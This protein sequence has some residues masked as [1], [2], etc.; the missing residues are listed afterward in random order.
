MILTTEPAAAREVCRL[1]LVLALDVSGSVDAAEYRLQLD[2]LAE[3]LTRP[4]VARTLLAGP[5]VALAAFEWS[6]PRETRPLFGWTML[7]GPETLADLA[8]R[9]R[10]TERSGMSERTAIGSAM[11]AGEALLRDGPDCWRRVI[12]ISGDGQSNS[13]PPPSALR[14]DGI[15]V[16]AL[17]V[18]ADDPSPGDRRA[19]EISELSSYFRVNVLRGPGAFVQVAL[20]FDDF[21]R[22][23]ARKLIREADPAI[24]SAR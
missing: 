5:P 10:A 19:A 11:R 4:E 1:A 21:A 13:G 22:A 18:G 2:G 12:D 14:L 9:L 23:M 20:G 15:T 3:A 24:L 17:V 6:G 8:G 7:R 16:N